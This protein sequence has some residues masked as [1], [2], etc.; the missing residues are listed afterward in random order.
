MLGRRRGCCSRAA[1]RRR[2]S[3]GPVRRWSRRDGD[4]MLIGTTNAMAMP[5]RSRASAIS[6]IILR[7]CSICSSPKNPIPQFMPTCTMIASMLGSSATASSVGRTFWPSQ[8]DIVSTGLRMPVPA[9]GVT[10]A[11]RLSVWSLQRRQLESL[12]LDVVGALDG[13]PA[14]ADDQA[15]PGSGGNGAEAPAD[16]QVD[17]FLHVVDEDGVGLSGGSGPDLAGACER[18]GVGLRGASA[19]GQQSAL[20]DGDRAWSGRRCA[21]IGRS[22]G[23]RACLRCRRR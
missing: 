14:S 10:S 13:D 5:C 2:R 8:S 18:S 22:R 9:T 21:G 23:R 19:G 16:E 4:P 15:D 20:E 17:H 7:R 12:A 3:C 6:E 1:G 11:S